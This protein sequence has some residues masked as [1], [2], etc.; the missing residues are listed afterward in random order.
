MYETADAR[1][2]WRKTMQVIQK[3]LH[4][5]AAHVNVYWLVESIAQSQLG[6]EKQ[7]KMV[8]IIAFNGAKIERESAECI[9]VLCARIVLH[10]DL[11]VNNYAQSHASMSQRCAAHLG[12][13]A[14]GKCTVI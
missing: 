13:A 6:A 9:L 5:C 14:N 7:R 2:I 4:G 10:C 11:K 8:I 12:P 1:F 3:V